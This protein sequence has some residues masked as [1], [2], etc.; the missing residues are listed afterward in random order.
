MLPDSVDFY[1]FCMDVGL[2][3]ALPKVDIE[4]FD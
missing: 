2:V 3:W 1:L 4:L